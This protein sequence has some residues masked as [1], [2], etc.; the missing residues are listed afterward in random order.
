MRAKKTRPNLYYSRRRA[1]STAKTGKFLALPGVQKLRKMDYSLGEISDALGCVGRHAVN[2]WR[3]GLARPTVH[4]REAVFQHFKIPIQDWLT[5]EE[6]AARERFIAAFE[7]GK[8]L[9]R[10]ASRLHREYQRQLGK[11]PASE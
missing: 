6:V 11:A 1:K 4:A 3:R 9:G 7:S 10:G 5:P 8:D 2:K